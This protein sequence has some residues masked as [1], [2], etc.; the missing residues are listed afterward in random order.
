[1]ERIIKFLNGKY[2]IK[3]KGLLFTSF[4]DLDDLPSKNWRTRR[5]KYFTCCLDT[6]EK[7]EE[8]MRNYFDGLEIVEEY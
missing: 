8:V 6:K 1:M 2:A 4:L 5:N 7:C 3:K